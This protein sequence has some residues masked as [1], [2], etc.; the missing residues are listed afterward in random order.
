[1]WDVIFIVLTI[2][3]RALLVRPGRGHT[4]GR[5]HR[6]TGLDGRGLS[7]RSEKDRE[8]LHGG[9]P[10]Q[11]LIPNAVVDARRHSCGI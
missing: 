9:N 6:F 5:K 4:A 7:A 1:M 3:E 10:R 2:R 8:P 11:I